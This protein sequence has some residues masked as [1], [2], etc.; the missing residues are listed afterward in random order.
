MGFGASQIKKVALLTQR[1]S[2]ASLRWQVNSS[3]SHACH[4]NTQRTNKPID[5][6]C[7]GSALMIDRQLLEMPP[8]IVFF[9]IC[10][11][12][13]TLQ[14]TWHAPKHKKPNMGLAPSPP[15]PHFFAIALLSRQWKIYIYTC[16]SLLVIL[17]PFSVIVC[18]KM[19]NMA[20]FPMPRRNPYD[21]MASIPL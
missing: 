13:S 17:Y 6:S 9:H 4:K 20:F 1:E 8:R 11:T 2:W 16:A 19:T 18:H 14:A 15:P 7:Q 21:W 5:P 3:C 10:P 12:K